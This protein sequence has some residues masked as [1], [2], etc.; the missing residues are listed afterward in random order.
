MVCA[1]QAAAFIHITLDVFVEMPE[2]TAVTSVLPLR[3]ARADTTKDAVRKLNRDHR[4]SHSAQSRHGLDL[5]LP[6]RECRQALGE[7]LGS[8]PCFFLD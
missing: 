8:E 2:P 4:P 1:K 7:Q 5:S 3:R 6:H